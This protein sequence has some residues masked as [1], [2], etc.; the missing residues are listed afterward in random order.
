MWYEWKNKGV[1]TANPADRA[2]ERAA[3]QIRRKDFAPT[4]SRTAPCLQQAAVIASTAEILRH[5]PFV[6]RQ[7]KTSVSA[8]LFRTLEWARQVDSRLQQRKAF[9]EFVNL[10]GQEMKAH[11]AT[12]RATDK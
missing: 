2:L 10:I 6:F 8:A 9:A 4:V 3:V 11:P 7:Q 1:R 12:R 5:S